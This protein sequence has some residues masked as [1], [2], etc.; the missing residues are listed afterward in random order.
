[1]DGSLAYQG[2]LYGIPDSN[3]YPSRISDSP[4]ATK[5]GGGGGG[6]WENFVLL[7]FFVARNITKF[8]K[9]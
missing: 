6:N 8:N 1:M 7:P 3:F 5:K 9:Y 4:T 2:C